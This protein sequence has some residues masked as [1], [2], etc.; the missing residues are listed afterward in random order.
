MPP[1]CCPSP[2]KS[3]T[4]ITALL[5]HTFSHSP[6]LRPDQLHCCLMQ[7]VEVQLGAVSLLLVV[8]LAARQPFLVAAESVLW[9]MTGLLMILAMLGFARPDW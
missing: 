1:R 6:V 3:C 5:F 2:H 8:F 4:I 9:P 7:Q